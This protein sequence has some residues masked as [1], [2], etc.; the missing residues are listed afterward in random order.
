VRCPARP[1]SRGAR[2]GTVR[3]RL[4]PIP[5]DLSSTGRQNDQLKK[6]SGNRFDR[7]WETFVMYP[8]V[9][10]RLVYAGE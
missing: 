3:G 10:M 2:P 1:L 8:G 5:G 9:F 4:D 6:L 7:K